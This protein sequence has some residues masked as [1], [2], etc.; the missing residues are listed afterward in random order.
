MPYRTLAGPSTFEDEPVKGSRFVALVAPCASEEEALA[1]VGEA[2]ERWPDAS[3]HTWA[4]T[5][6]D[7]RH[8][9]SDAGEPGGSAGRPILAQIQGH[10]LCDV[11]AVV[12]RWF[13]GTKLGVGGLIR[14][15]GGCAGR[16]LDRAEVV[17][18]TPTVE[19]T[20][21]HAYDDVGAV[22]AVVASLGLEVLETRW[23]QEVTLVLRVPEPRREEVRSALLDRTAGRADIS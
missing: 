16:A 6:R 2:R 3:H 22:Q 10:G 19:L 4:Y 23:E 11:V 5:L 17:E 18:V 14:A 8:R 20:V 7:G 1:V 15:Y 9:T 12:V 13:G 21:R